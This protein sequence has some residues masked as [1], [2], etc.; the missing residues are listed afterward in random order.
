MQ[1]YIGMVFILRIFFKSSLFAKEGKYLTLMYIIS[2]RALKA[3]LCHW[4]FSFSKLSIYYNLYLFIH[5]CINYIFRKKYE[6]RKS[7]THGSMPEIPGATLG[8]R[9]PNRGETYYDRR[10]PS[11][12]P[13]LTHSFSSDSILDNNNKDNVTSTPNPSVYV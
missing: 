1:L 6:S 13:P 8:N 3:F 10:T 7:Q 2:L 4:Y 11:P 12:P 9:L 5:V